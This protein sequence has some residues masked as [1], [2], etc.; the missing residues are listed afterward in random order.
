MRDGTV[1]W[2]IVAVVAVACAAGATL[3]VKLSRPAPDASAR[4]PNAHAARA[5]PQPD[6]DLPLLVEVGG[7]ECEACKAMSPVLEAIRREY[8]GRVR[9]ERVDFK[10]QPRAAEFYG[11]RQ[12][13]TQ[14]VYEPNG[15]EVFRHLG[16]LPR[17][18][19]VEAL[20]KAGLE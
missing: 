11:V 17:E 13:P 19:A 20:R 12:I 1:Q 6:G 4:E 5:L 8:A 16:F 14:I 15:R 10:K 2:K 9:V 18:K 3:A 7:T